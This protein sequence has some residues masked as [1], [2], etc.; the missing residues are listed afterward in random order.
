MLFRR[1][2]GR[3]SGEIYNQIRPHTALKYKTSDEVHRAF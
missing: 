3:E 2:N 1:E